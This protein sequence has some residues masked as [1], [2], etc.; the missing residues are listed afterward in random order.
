MNTKRQK[1]FFSLL[2]I[3]VI[4]F[5]LS[6]I[7]ES[8]AENRAFRNLQSTATYLLSL[9]C[10]NSPCVVIGDIYFIKHKYKRGQRGLSIIAGNNR[11]ATIYQY[12]FTVDG[13]TY[14]KNDFSI[15][16]KSGLINSGLYYLPNAKFTLNKKFSEPILY[17]PNNPD[18]NLPLG[19]AKV[20]PQIPP[21]NTF[22]WYLILIGIIVI[23]LIYIVKC[24][25]ESKSTH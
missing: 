9:Q 4:F 22:L 10:G 14:Q 21:P 3:I 25:Q 17:D 1:I 15:L 12:F 13:V 24:L 11:E 8:M 16:G 6:G 23:S 2:L 20:L 7:F 5:A 19:Y 18:I